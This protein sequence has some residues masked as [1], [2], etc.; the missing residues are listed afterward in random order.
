ML[1]HTFDTTRRGDEG[2]TCS[3]LSN[4]ESVIRNPRNARFRRQLEEEQ[5]AVDATEEEHSDLSKDAEQ[6]PVDD[7]GK[8]SQDSAEES[9]DT[10]EHVPKDKD[11]STEVAQ[12]SDKP[13]TTEKQAQAVD[14]TPEYVFE[15]LF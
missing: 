8:G 4:Y 12:Q 9:E 5:A 6:I 13:D 15:F 3:Q 10:S 2:T 14:Q 1:S 7:T 11:G